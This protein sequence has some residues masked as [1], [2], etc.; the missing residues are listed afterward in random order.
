MHL[1]SID[2]P[3]VWYSVEIDCVEGRHNPAR[4][5]PLDA[6]APAWADIHFALKHR[7]PFAT[8]KPAGFGGL[9]RQGMIDPFGR[10]IINTLDRESCMDGGTGLRRLG[11]RRMLCVNPRNLP[12]QLV[13][14]STPP[15]PSA[16]NRAQ[17]GFVVDMVQLMHGHERAGPMIFE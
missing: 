16:L 7:V 10:G 6:L 3:F 4:P 11:V 17:E 1:I 2:E 14:R 9:V 15:L 8:H 12:L 13:E 5:A